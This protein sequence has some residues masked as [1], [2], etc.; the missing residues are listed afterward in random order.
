MVAEK[1]MRSSVSTRSAPSTRLRTGSPIEAMSVDSSRAC[2]PETS[3]SGCAGGRK[4][5]NCLGAGREGRHLAQELVAR[6]RGQVRSARPDTTRRPDGSR[7]NRAGRGRGSTTRPPSRRYTSALRRCRPADN[8]L[9]RGKPPS[10]GW[11]GKCSK[12]IATC[13][14]LVGIGTPARAS[15]SRL[16]INA[17]SRSSSKC[18][19]PLPTEAAGMRTCRVRRRG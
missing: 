9:R 10:A 7:R 18:A 4:L 12:S 16:S 11:R 8:A 2:S 15:R 3:G 6:L 13:V 17:V 14:T 5:K 19:A 1:P